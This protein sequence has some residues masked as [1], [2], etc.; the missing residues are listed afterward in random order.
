MPISKFDE[1]DLPEQHLLAVRGTVKAENIAAFL[2]PAYGRIAHR[3]RALGL[4]QTSAPMARYLGMS[5]AGFDMQAA[6]R[7]ESAA[8]GEGDVESLTL[9]G[10]RAA[11][12]PH[13]SVP[14]PRTGLRGRAG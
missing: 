9:P 14:G 3:A 10:R 2:G 1:I 7:F 13:R 12:D 6:V 4:Q 11:V 5:D 8:S